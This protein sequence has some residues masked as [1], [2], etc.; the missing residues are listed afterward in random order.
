[1][2]NMVI[3]PKVHRERNFD[4][5]ESLLQV[6]ACT[7]SFFVSGFLTGWMQEMYLSK[8]VHKFLFKIEYSKI[9]VLLHSFSV[10]TLFSIF[11]PVWNISRTGM[12]EVVVF[13][14]VVILNN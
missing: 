6:A 10:T 4:S 13:L 11:C 8:K 7:D 1:M 9:L 14:I 5:V 2:L 12:V 3:L